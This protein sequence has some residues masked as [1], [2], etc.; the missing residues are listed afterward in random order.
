MLPIR[1]LLATLTILVGSVVSAQEGP[2]VATPEKQHE[3]LKQFVGEWESESRMATGGDPE[4]PAMKGTMS[5]SMLGSLWA[6]NQVKIID[7]GGTPMHAIQTIGYDPASGK[8]IGTWVDSMMNHMWR[9]EGTVDAAGKKLS[10]EADGPDFNNPG[11]MARFRDAYEFE[12]ADVIIA[13]SSMKSEGGEWVTFMTG[14][15]TRKKE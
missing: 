13:T 7:M 3:W 1:Y 6:I 14:R 9:Y 5:S 2:P 4:A 12:S 15:M 8:Y 10:L 11:K